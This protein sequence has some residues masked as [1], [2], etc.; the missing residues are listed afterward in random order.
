MHGGAIQESCRS[1]DDGKARGHNLVSAS[2]ATHQPADLDQVGA[3]GRAVADNAPEKPIGGFASD[4][5]SAYRQ[6]TADPGRA[7]DFAVT[8]W[9][10]LMQ[11]CFF[12]LAVTQLF[13]SGNAPQLRQDSRR[14]LPY[15]F[16]VLRDP[17][18]TLS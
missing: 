11:R 3:L 2:T 16:R 13:G 18:Y 12:L 15:A 1:I 14:I 10:P 6:V 4:F 5:K 7:L 8:S 9:D 17:G